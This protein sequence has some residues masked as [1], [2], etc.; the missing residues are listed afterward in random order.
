M[1]YKWV[2]LKGGFYGGTIKSSITFLLYAFHAPLF[3]LL[4]DFIGNEIHK[5]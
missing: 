2:L 1:I 5:I 3:P 4:S